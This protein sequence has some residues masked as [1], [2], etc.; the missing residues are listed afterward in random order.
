MAGDL[1]TLS[2]PQLF[3]EWHDVGSN[4]VSF[5]DEIVGGNRLVVNLS[6]I[7]VIFAPKVEPRFDCDPRRKVELVE[8]DR[9]DESVIVREKAIDSVELSYFFVTDLSKRLNASTVTGARVL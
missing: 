6:G 8:R 4:D 5:V 2:F 1:D 7:P 9:R 3:S